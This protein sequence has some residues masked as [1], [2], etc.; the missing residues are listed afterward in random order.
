MTKSMATWTLAC[1]L[2]L[3]LAASAQADI[4][5]YDGFEDGNLSD[6]TVAVGNGT[7]W[8]A[9]AWTAAGGTGGVVVATSPAPPTGGGTYEVT[10][11]APRSISRTV[12]LSQASDVKLSLA[13][14]TRYWDNGGENIVIEFH[15][16]A[17]WNTVDTLTTASTGSSGS[18]WTFT[19]EY[20]LSGYTLTGT[21]QTIRMTSNIG[22]SDWVYF[23]EIKITG[24]IPEPASLSLLALSGLGLLRR[25]RA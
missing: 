2:G 16:G 19:Q 18:P 21:S 12:D 5:A 20:D 7:G 11:S 6:A 4:I 25:R 17:D 9:N 23:D 1:V 22:S 3:I 14:K 8:L 10:L 15:D 24:I 13:W